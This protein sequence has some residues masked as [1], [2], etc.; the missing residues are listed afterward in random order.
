MKQI[1]NN[2]IAW[3]K[4]KSRFFL[5]LVLALAMPLFS[6]CGNQT[7]SYAV[8]LE[9]WGPLDES[10][11]YNEVIG[12]YRGINPYVGEIKYRKFSQDTYK[13]EL[14]DA[15][16]SGQGPDIFLV[17]NAWLPSFVNKLEPAPTPL[18]SQ[19][20][21]NMNFPDVVATDFVD[22][23]KVY[24][25]PLSVDSLQLY[26]NKDI[27]NAVGITVPPVTWQD[28]SVDVQKTTKVDAV[29][30]ISRAGTAMGTSQNVSRFADVLSLLM[31]QN[32]VQLPTSKESFAKIDQGVL[33]K[34]GNVVQAGEQ[35]L[36][37]YTQFSRVSLLSNSTNPLYCWNSRQHNSID[38]FAAGEVAMMVNY[39]SQNANLRN[40]NPKLNFGV[41][42]VPQVN[43]ATPAS[44]AN[45]WGYGVSKN[46]TVATSQAGSVS[47]PV[48]N[49]IRIHEAWQ[50]L[51]FLTLK[52]S[53]S[54]TLYNAVTKNSKDF[55]INYDPALE[56]LK[57]T[58]QPAAR[59][60]LIELQKTDATLGVFASGN[61][62][63]KSWYQID[64]D[65]V[66]NIFAEAVDS[67]GRG[68]VS[69]HQALV[70]MTNR[71][72]ALNQGKK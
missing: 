42:P 71:L 6:G 22:N 62:I 9:I 4:N 70:L 66:Y 19:Q 29:G 67:I 23:G 57:K 25:L 32:G 51:R 56:Y 24:A 48:S 37:F 41:A 52:N 26:Y 58:G 16:A 46:K 50:F 69:L 43:S 39:F 35:A 15:L 27:F 28:F 2:T 63:A 30:N 13:Q 12:K 54:V 3:M 18:A 60:D 34:D 8:P 5:A 65:S 72:N 49:E 11:N 45:Y 20:D 10:I 33:D 36:N 17:G 68:D 44:V 31:L 47:T 59:R 21:V 55:A 64:Q 53:G 61:L 7:Q 40:K 1:K 38:A 14:L